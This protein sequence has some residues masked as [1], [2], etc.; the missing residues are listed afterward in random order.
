MEN[1]SSSLLE[2][3]NIHANPI[4]SASRKKN[5]LIITLSKWKCDEIGIQ[6]ANI[7]IDFLDARSDKI[8][9]QVAVCWLPKNAVEHEGR[10][11]NLNYADI[12]HIVG[13]FTEFTTKCDQ[14]KLVNWIAKKTRE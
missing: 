4:L 3:S 13:S 1:K 11:E 5:V 12:V 10:I 6:D 2:I 8:A 9:T 14:E 7:Y